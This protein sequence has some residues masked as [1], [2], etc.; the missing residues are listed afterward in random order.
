MVWPT[1][2]WEVSTVMNQFVNQPL[3]VDSAEIG[4][5]ESRTLDICATEIGVREPFRVSCR[6]YAG[7]NSGWRVNG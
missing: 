7:G 3:F 5:R 4:L 6:S 2:E 1:V